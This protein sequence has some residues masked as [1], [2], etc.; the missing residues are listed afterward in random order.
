MNIDVRTSNSSRDLRE[1]IFT[2]VSSIAEQSSDGDE[3]LRRLADEFL[4]EFHAALVAVE[5]SDWP[6]PVMVVG[7]RRTAMDVPRDEIKRLLK[8][9]GV[10]PAASTVREE[11]SGSTWRAL[12]VEVTPQPDR[13]AMLLVYQPENQPNASQQV[14][15][16]KRLNFY[17]QG[18]R[19]RISKSKVSTKPTTI[20]IRPTE[21]SAAA[22]EQRNL[23]SHD[24]SILHRSL[25][26][27]ET[28]YRIVNET[29]RWTQVDRVSL[30]LP[31]RKRAQVIAVSGVEKV[32]RRAATVRYLERLTDAVS[33]F[34][35]PILLPSAEPQADAV[36]EPLNEY[37]DTSQST[38][39][40]YLPLTSEDLSRQSL[41]DMPDE[42]EKRLAGLNGSALI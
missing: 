38:Q 1:A 40:L 10:G 17:S 42:E 32:D 25:S 12:H 33:V 5:R 14:G 22:T 3:L 9:A 34:E 21:F 31:K 37:L 36:V 41:E 8:R 18:I 23:Q 13:L 16:L 19:E 39:I 29:R 15:D 2:R 6:Q 27:D 4:T 20:P 26:L 35:K 28:A 7:Q 24:L 11:T 30:V